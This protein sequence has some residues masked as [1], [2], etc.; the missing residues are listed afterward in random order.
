MEPQG[1][2]LLLSETGGLVGFFSSSSTAGW[3][4]TQEQNPMFILQITFLLHFCISS[5]PNRVEMLKYLLN[6]ITAELKF[7]FKCW[8]LILFLILLNIFK[9]LL[10]HHQYTNKFF[11]H[12]TRTI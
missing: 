12:K 10:S 6:N 4:Q 2:N 3:W 9:S 11:L 8:H 1:S 7:R 5:T